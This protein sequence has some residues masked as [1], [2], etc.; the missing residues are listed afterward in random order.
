[1][2]QLSFE[3]QGFSAV[4]YRYLRLDVGNRFYGDE[5]YILD[6]FGL[7]YLPSV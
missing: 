1:M 4:P 5:G 6:L 2:F 7:S 3:Y